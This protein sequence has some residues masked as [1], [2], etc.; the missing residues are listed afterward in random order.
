MET[1]I[2]QLFKT[3]DGKKAR[4]SSGGLCAEGSVEGNVYL[5]Y[6]QYKGL[7]L[8]AKAKW[9]SSLELNKTIRGFIR[10]SGLGYAVNDKLHELLDSTK[11]VENARVTVGLVSQYG[12][13]NFETYV[14]DKGDITYLKLKYEDSTVEIQIIK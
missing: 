5:R 12:I 7:R 11:L 6:I 1:I 9:N 10:D 8:V 3:L 4:V 14:S 13:K 2:E